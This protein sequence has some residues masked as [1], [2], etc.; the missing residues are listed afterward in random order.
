MILNMRDNEIREEGREEGRQEGHKN[1]ILETLVGL[2]KDKILDIKE[3]ARRA[4]LREAQ[5]C[6]HALTGITVN[7]KQTRVSPFAAAQPTQKDETL[8]ALH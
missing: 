5:N 2:V 4:N 6:P 3:A 1:G 7:L 8:C